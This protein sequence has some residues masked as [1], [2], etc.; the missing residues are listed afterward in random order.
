MLGCLSIAIFLLAKYALSNGKA[1]MLDYITVAVLLAMLIRHIIVLTL[2][3]W[4][5]RAKGPFRKYYQLLDECCD[6]LIHY[7][8]A[9]SYKVSKTQRVYT[10]GPIAGAIIALIYWGYDCFTTNPLYTANRLGDV[11]NDPLINW[12]VKLCFLTSATYCFTASIVTAVY[13]L[14]VTHIQEYLLRQF[15]S[16][17]E[18]EIN[19]H[20]SLTSERLHHSRRAFLRLSNVVATSNTCWRYIIGTDNTV[21]LFLELYMLWLVA[22]LAKDAFDTSTQSYSEMQKSQVVL[23]VGCTYILLYLTGQIVAIRAIDKVHKQVS[24][25]VP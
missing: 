6:S 17:L 8:A 23:F 11:I 25:K 19:Q 4:N 21:C 3:F 5:W 24:Q 7:G 10:V 18:E 13:F 20:L 14:N 1:E 2:F 12:T 22:V 16:R 9:I 15:N